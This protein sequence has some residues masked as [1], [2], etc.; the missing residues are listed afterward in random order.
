MQ[1]LKQY[2][3][4]QLGTVATW[5]LLALGLLI[6]VL[7]VW[8][9]IRR[10]LG[11]RLNM[12]DRPDRRGRPPRLGITESFAVDRQGRRLVIVRRDNV[13]HLVMIG[14]P[15]DVVVEA[16]IV[17]GE[18]L[19]VGRGEMRNADS[20]LIPPMVPEALPSPPRAVEARFVQPVAAEVPR[21]EPVKFEPL[22]EP[23]KPE[24]VKVA[25]PPVT[26]APSPPPPPPPPPPAPPA[27]PA[28]KI[29]EPPKVSVPKVEIPKVEIPKAEPSKV[30]PMMAEAP[31]AVD[32]APPPAPAA[33]RGMTLAERIKSGFALHA[34][35]DGA[36]SSPKAAN[37]PVEPPQSPPPAP[38]TPPPAPPPAPEPPPAPKKA[39][40]PPPPPPPP[41]E[42]K[43][44]P[45]A[46]E[47]VQP[48]PAPDVPA[49]TATQRNPFD[50]LEEE[51]A[52]LLGRA[53]DGKT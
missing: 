50:S 3:G 11:D 4:D 38:P 12:S 13:E 23:P 2:L 22:P 45:K 27:Q 19:G 5:A 25:P 36:T 24:P 1:I 21:P 42:P 37:R 44:V 41:P 43:V 46:A 20:D 10:A 14:G 30:Q 33:P 47:P 15:N 16:N 7:V 17:R 40:A 28:P 8:S 6:I 35:S 34:P 52:R 18:R 53:P 26:A 31:P 29:E 9:L 49:K 48:P 32:V 39:A 51:M